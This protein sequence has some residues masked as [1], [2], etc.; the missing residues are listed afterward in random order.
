MEK[1]RP[2]ERPAARA[3]SGGCNVREKRAS[4]RHDEDMARTAI[5]DNESPHDQVSL[6]QRNLLF[7]TW[8]SSKAQKSS[9]LVGR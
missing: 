6:F 8:R 1:A 3:K 9:I 2:G 7:A 4:S 5:T